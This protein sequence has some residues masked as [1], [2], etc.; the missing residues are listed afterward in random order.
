MKK[1]FLALL[2]EK[3]PEKAAL[4][5]LVLVKYGNKQSK[6]LSKQDNIVTS[7]DNFFY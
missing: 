4:T 1:I 2:V 5:S 7:L 3:L 6:K